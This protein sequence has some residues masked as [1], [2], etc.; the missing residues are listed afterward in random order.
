MNDTQKKVLIIEDDAQISKVYD[1]QLTKEGIITMLAH[2]GEEAMIL[3]AKDNPDIIILD[4][5]IPRKD[6][7]WVL[8]EIRQNHEYSDV[9]VVVISNLGQDVD[10]AR[11]MELGATEYLVKI[12]NSIQ[13]IVDKVK[14]YIGV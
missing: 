13:S 12:D 4:L 9:P 10:R 11:A 3:L 14:G 7:F 8:N 5:M 6:G 1:I 2:N